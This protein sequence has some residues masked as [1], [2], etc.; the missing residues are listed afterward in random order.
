MC[1]LATGLPATKDAESRARDHRFA[2]TPEAMSQKPL[3]TTA[4]ERM[5]LVA[6][7]EIW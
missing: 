6:Q 4:A 7:D 1:Y 2:E 3:S 5:N